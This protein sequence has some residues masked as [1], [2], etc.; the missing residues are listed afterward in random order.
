M[1]SLIWLAS[2]PKSGSTWTRAFLAAYGSDAKGPMDLKEIN[3]FSR[4]ESRR[5]MFAEVAVTEMAQKDT[6]EFTEL[7]I[8]SLREKVQAKLA[9]NFPKYCTIK[10][11]NLRAKHNGFPLIRREYTKAAV[12]IV[13][14]PLDVVD[15]FADHANQTIDKMIDSL[16]DRN[17][18]LGGPNTDLVTQYLDTWSNHVE[19]WLSADKAFPLLVMRYEDMQ[20][21]PWE[22][23]GGLIQ[24]LGWEFD[25]ERL[26]RALQYSDIRVLQQCEAEQG[27]EEMSP[28]ARSQRFFRHGVVDRWKTVLTE[29]QI[30]TIC[31]QHGPTM[32]KLGYVDVMEG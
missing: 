7:E 26:E 5:T 22:V 20:S 29:Q 14:N 10:T 16:N 17:H 31:E 27:F 25:E 23:F 13:R 2:Y 11:H 18:R 15:S 12:Y 28:V 1:K 24:F 19:S 32:E 21:R 8:D 9:R 30:E 3:R 4:S 6:N